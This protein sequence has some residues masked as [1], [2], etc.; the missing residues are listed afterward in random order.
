MAKT[1]VLSYFSNEETADDAVAALKAW[2]KAD[3]DIK[4]N[5]IGVLVLDDK[6]KVKAH[7]LGQAERREGRWHRIAPRHRSRRL[8]S[9]PASSVVG[10]SG[11]SITRA[12][13]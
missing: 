4:L 8:R 9:S 1:V 2:D 6:G 5:A 11:H 13:A 7:K 10:S 12:L 3:D